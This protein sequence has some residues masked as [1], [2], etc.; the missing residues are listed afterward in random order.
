MKMHHNMTCILVTALC[1][2][3]EGFAAELGDNQSITYVTTVELC[4]NVLLG[5]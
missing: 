3:P 1:I 2:Q 4:Y 5:S